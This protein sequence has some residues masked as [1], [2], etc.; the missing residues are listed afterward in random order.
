MRGVTKRQ[1][2]NKNKKAKRY[3]LYD[4]RDIVLYI[5]RLYERERLKI[6]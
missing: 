2:P 6:Q 4:G 3:N 1:D 5:F